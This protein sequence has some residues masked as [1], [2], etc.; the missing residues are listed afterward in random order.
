M[1]D[2]DFY[3][4]VFVLVLPMA[5]QNL[6]NVGVT[7]SDVIMLG[8]VGEK[9]LSGASLGGQVYFIL[10]LIFF[11][12]TSGASV[13]TAQ[14]WGRKDINTIEKILGMALR[15]TLIISSVFT[16]VTLC[17]PQYLM[18]IFSS[19]REVINQ[20]AMYLR[21]VCISYI[22]A[23]LTMVYLNL[24]RSVERVMISTIVYFISFISNIILNAILIFGF[25]GFPAMGV[26]G[27]ALGTTISRC[28][29]LMI[30]IFYSTVINREVK[31]R[32]RYCLTTDKW[33]SSDFV[34]FSLPVVLNE[35][36]WGVGMSANAAILGHLGSSVTAANSV[37]QVMRQLAMV[38]C[39]GLA[40][41]TA[42]MIGKSIGEGKMNQA[43][44]YGRRFKNLSLVLGVCG[45]VIVLIIRPVVMNFMT[46]SDEA[47][48]YMGMM[49][50]V[51]AYYVVC[52]AFN[53]TMIVGVF[54]AGGDTKYGLF[55]DTSTLWF[56]SILFGFLAAYVFKL[57]VTAVY[58][59]V[60]CD[61]ALKIPLCLYRYY[62]Y[63]W[64]KNVTRENA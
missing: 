49:T 52:Q 51:I 29:E 43:K 53:T 8:R 44:E 48:T 56:G 16:I 31:V 34:K 10:N 19:D 28:I 2:K 7:S 33:L 11:G 47:V 45:A 39:F 4:K 24:M 41:A 14:Y 21:I 5:L 46:V 61:E 42:I 17:F 50:L 9:V 26:R 59:I 55:A 15:I 20:G 13:L 3:K 37:A 54:R 22:P 63:K 32:F 57:S 38:I 35:M 25:L 27:A 23:T 62:S 1:K 36:L 64:L 30:V 60:M 18:M 12:L 6:I 40:N 58:I